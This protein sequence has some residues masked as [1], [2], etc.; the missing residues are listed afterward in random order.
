MIFFAPSP[1]GEGKKFWKSGWA[2]LPEQLLR[3]S[4]NFKS[5]KIYRNLDCEKRFEEHASRKVVP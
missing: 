5:D 1:G 3:H 2:I 4:E